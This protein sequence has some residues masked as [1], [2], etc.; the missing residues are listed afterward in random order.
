[1]K[2]ILKIFISAAIFVLLAGCDKTDEFFEN[3]TPEL[4]KAQV[5]VTMPFE[6][7]L[8]GEITKI[9]FEAHECIDEGYAVRAIVEC[10]G[11]AT[12]MGKVSLTFNFCSGGAPDPEVEGSI[13]TFAGCQVDLIAANGD[14][15]YLYYNDGVA[16]GGRTEEHPEHVS[17][18]WRTP[19]AVLGGTGKFEG[20]S[21]ELS[22]DDYVTTDDVT[23]HRFYGE[24]TLL[25]SKK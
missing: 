11:N 13:Y 21:G 23:H 7:N 22:S 12:H 19:I 4:K 15:L 2:T 14:V 18:Y 20:A 6:A 24:I 3:E 10:N 5:E 9:D 16:I 17:E 1:M 8:L 25:K